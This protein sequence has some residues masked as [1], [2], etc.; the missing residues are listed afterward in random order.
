MQWFQFS[1]N[2]INFSKIYQFMH[3][4]AQWGVYRKR[5]GEYG[6]TVVDCLCTGF[7]PFNNVTNVLSMGNQV[8]M[9]IIL[10]TLL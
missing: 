4:E 3:E 2:V 10:V 7:Y 8:I 6:I 5:S 9:V 1:Q